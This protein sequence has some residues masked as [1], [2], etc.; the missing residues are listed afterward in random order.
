LR[1]EGKDPFVVEG[2]ERSSIYEYS[3]TTRRGVQGAGSVHHIAWAAEVDDH[4][5][6]H[7]RLRDAGIDV[8]PII[9]R[10]YFQS[11]YFREPSGV[12]FE[13]ATKGPG[14][15]IDETV[16]E[17]GTGLRLPPQ[18]ESLRSS[19]VENLVPLENPRTR[20]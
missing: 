16:D 4:A 15:A 17:L 5:E 3:S 9:D 19:L 2:P 6:W 10:T 14:F 1:F 11:I 7:R 8:T 12:L 20:A 18:H 13:I